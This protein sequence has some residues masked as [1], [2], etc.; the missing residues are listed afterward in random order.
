VGPLPVRLPSA[1]FQRRLRLFLKRV[2]KLTTPSPA[3][4]QYLSFVHLPPLPSFI[5]HRAPSETSRLDPIRSLHQ[6]PS[7][8]FVIPSIPFLPFFPSKAAQIVKMSG[9]M[10]SLVRR[11]FEAVGDGNK[12][13]VVKVDLP[14]WGAFLLAT[15]FA[16]F[17]FVIF[18]VR[19][20]NML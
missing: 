10:T 7:S 1:A 13:P 5:I 2:S 8:F 16:A 14:T 20:R 4:V 12:P 19:L 3:Y 15:T 6:I 11:G 17:L 18:M 9:V